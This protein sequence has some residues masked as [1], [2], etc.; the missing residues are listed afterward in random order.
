MEI[1]RIT[2]FETEDALDRFRAVRRGMPYK[3]LWPSDVDEAI[4]ALEEK[5]NRRPAPENKHGLDNP[6]ADGLKVKY[7]VTKLEDGSTVH[8]CFVLRPD[9]D[10]AAVKA[11]QAYAAATQNKVLADDIYAWVGTPENKPLT[12]EQLRQMDG[13]PVWESWTGSWRIVTTAH[14]GETTSLYNA[15]NSIS[16]KSVLYNGGR[17]YARKPEQEE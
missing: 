3:S 10:P 11:L 17:I 14:D 8:D 9:K 13:E 2:G 7:N 5:L 6:G 16:A 4:E 12:M 1:K 15:Y